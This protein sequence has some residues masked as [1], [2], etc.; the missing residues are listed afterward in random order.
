MSQ[1]QTQTQ[2]PYVHD[3]RGCIRNDGAVH[4]AHGKVPLLM[5]FTKNNFRRQ[6][7]TCGLRQ[8][9]DNKCGF[10]VWLDKLRE[11][12]DWDENLFRAAYPQYRP[13]DANL[14]APET[15]LKRRPS[16]GSQPG[17]SLPSKRICH[18]QPDSDEEF[19]TSPPASMNRATSQ[20]HSIASRT[21]TT[22]SR[23]GIGRTKTRAEWPLTPSSPTREPQPVSPSREAVR[24]RETRVSAQLPHLQ[25]FDGVADHHHHLSPLSQASQA[26]QSLP[27][28]AVT[29]ADE[30]EEMF[31]I[32]NSITVDYVRKLER[33]SIA[34]QKASD[35]K[36]ARIQQLEAELEG[37]R[38]EYEKS[39]HQINELNRENERFQQEVIM[40]TD[41]L[42]TC[43]SD[44]LSRLHA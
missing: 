7:F 21:C 27:A 41:K 16:P 34:S 35:A 9:N 19:F 12:D 14:A 38:R 3:I 4:C 20:S 24:R 13:P 6:F 5:S 31:N 25:N 44:K 29:S 43:E 8:G 15:P 30:V 37:S 22:P 39:Q 33:R 26:A 40:L 36:L 1:S 17:P 11:E 2:S 23:E 42:R 18:G 28:R 32:T 10:F